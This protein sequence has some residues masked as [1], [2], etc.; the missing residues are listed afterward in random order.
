M[1]TRVVLKRLSVGVYG[2]ISDIRVID[3]SEMLL[4]M[5]AL[6]MSQ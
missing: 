5:T 3:T 2:F 4:P 1:P 6:A